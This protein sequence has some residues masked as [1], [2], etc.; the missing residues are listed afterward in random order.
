VSL[1]EYVT[2]VVFYPSLPAGPI[3]RVERFVEDLRKPKS[4]TSQDWF[5]A[6]KRIL[7][8]V[9]KKFVLADTL[10]YF[11]LSGAEAASVQPGLWTWLV[12]YAFSFQIF[13]DFSG[14]TDIAIGIARLVGV[15]LPENFSS[16][17]LRSN[18]TQF[19]N[20][21]HISLTQWL[22]SYFFNPLTRAL[23]SNRI[24][25][26]TAI[27]LTMQLSTMLVIGLWHGVALR[28]VFWG[29]WHG[30]GLFVQNRWSDFARIRVENWANTPLRKN[31]LT[32]A[33]IFLTFHYVTIGWL[34]FAMP[35]VSLALE[36]MARLFGRVG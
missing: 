7:L 11:T 22:K 19:W 23:R 16:P 4:L 14:Y 3:D 5:I 29:L 17:Y 25:P 9:F 27:I 8:G 32:F 36:L 30:F 21:W 35:S 34:F 28:F 1:G 2:F 33:G 10:A 31:L 13:F 18:L 6:G 26:A 12:I 20:S 15:K 24:L